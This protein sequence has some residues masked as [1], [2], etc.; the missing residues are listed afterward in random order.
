MTIANKRKPLI[1][2]YYLQDEILKKSDKIKYLGVTIDQKL[3]FKDHIN[4]K[5]KSASTV[6]NMLRRNLHFA[7]ASVKM[8]AYKSCVMPI[9]EYAN[10]CWAPTSAK[11]T[12]SMI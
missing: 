10:I 9:I 1:Q 2:K 5:C 4:E 11:H 7:P 8:K 12:N 6:L 3:S